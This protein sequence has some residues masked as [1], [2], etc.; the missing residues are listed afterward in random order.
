MLDLPEHGSADTGFGGEAVA[1]PTEKLARGRYL[2]ARYQKSPCECGVRIPCPHNRVRTPGGKRRRHAGAG[3][4]INIG[5]VQLARAAVDLPQE[6]PG[7]AF[8]FSPPP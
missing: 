4:R 5:S 6:A 1:G 8:A 2:S 3:E 7:L